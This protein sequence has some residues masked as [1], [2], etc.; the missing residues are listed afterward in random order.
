MFDNPQISPSAIFM[1]A[2]FSGESSSIENCSE[3]GLRII[4][5]NCLKWFLWREVAI[6]V[7][8]SDLKW[9]GQETEN[10]RTDIEKP[11]HYIRMARCRKQVRTYCI[12]ML[13]W[14]NWPLKYDIFML[15][16]SMFCS[17]MDWCHTVY[18]PKWL[19]TSLLSVISFHRPIKLLYSRAS[20]FILDFGKFELIVVS[21]IL[22]AFT[23]KCNF[24]S[25]S[26]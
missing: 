17:Q 1:R 26:I 13:V 23:R 16:N 11:V 8:K 10:W 2:H 19:G 20:R 22:W 5:I 3:W 21:F 18:H 7:F 15:F 9:I 12:A 25:W 6:D 14:V 4:L 24:L